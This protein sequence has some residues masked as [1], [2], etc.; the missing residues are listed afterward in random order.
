MAK[1]RALLLLLLLL[2][3]RIGCSGTQEMWLELRGGEA[4]TES[5]S[6]AKASKRTVSRES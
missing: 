1:K 2:S 5:P 6:L 4:A 3:P